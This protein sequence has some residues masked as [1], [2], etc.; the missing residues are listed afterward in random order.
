MRTNRGCATEKLGQV[1]GIRR[2]PIGALAI[3]LLAE[4]RIALELFRRLNRAHAHS[5]CLLP[6]PDHAFCSRVIRI[7]LASQP[8]SVCAAF[9]RAL[10]TAQIGAPLVNASA[11]A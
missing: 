7:R 6:K 1:M 9:S 11:M 8:T 2:N 5:Y 3:D 10:A 4:I